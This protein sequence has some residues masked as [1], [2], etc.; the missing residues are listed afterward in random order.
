MH[1][2]KSRALLRA[3]GQK[4]PKLV[5]R[6]SGTRVVHRHK[7]QYRARQPTGIVRNRGVAPRI[8]RKCG[9]T[10]RVVAR[11]MCRHGL[12]LRSGLLPLLP[13]LLLPC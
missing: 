3:E 10:T 2:H 12:L 5:I 1:G 6:A 11:I 4:P 8:G 9:C 7:S 13:L